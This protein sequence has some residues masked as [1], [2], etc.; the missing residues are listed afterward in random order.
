MLPSVYRASCLV[1]TF[2]SAEDPEPKILV[3]AA[4]V[5]KGMWRPRDE[6]S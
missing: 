1:T 2:N 5:N 3:Q 4:H 6:D